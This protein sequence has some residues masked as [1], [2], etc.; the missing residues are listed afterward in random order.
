MSRFHDTQPLHD[1]YTQIDQFI[2]ILFTGRS[3][4]IRQKQNQEIIKDL[5]SENQAPP[6]R[7]E[8]LDPIVKQQVEQIINSYLAPPRDGTYRCASC[9]ACSSCT[10]LSNLTRKQKLNL[11]RTRQNTEI[12]KNVAVVQDPSSPNKLRIIA[13]LPIDKN[14]MQSKNYGGVVHEFDTKM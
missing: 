5:T 10:P 6:L 1:E 4:L 8:C 14:D 12:Y 11:I 3:K 9:R 2:T 13:K 7:S